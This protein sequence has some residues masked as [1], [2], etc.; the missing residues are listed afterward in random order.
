MVLALIQEEAQQSLRLIQDN[1]LTPPPPRSHN[2]A[3]VDVETGSKL[4]EP[5][6]WETLHK[7]V[8]KM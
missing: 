7:D 3:T 1:S 6:G 5:R 8:S 4:I 2:L